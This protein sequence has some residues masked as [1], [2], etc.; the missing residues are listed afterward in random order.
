MAVARTQHV[1]KRF[2]T[3][4]VNLLMQR[5]YIDRSR[6]DERVEKQP[7]RTEDVVH[8]DRKELQEALF[9]GGRHGICSV[10]GIRPSVR[11]V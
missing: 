9:S 4:R 3:R 10:I 7:S 2:P 1:D 11:A 6:H 8:I 5:E